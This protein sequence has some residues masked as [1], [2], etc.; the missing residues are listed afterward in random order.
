MPSSILSL[1]HV[2][3]SS[4]NLEGIEN[5]PSCHVQQNVFSQ[6]SSERVVGTWFSDNG[7]KQTNQSGIAATCATR[8]MASGVCVVTGACSGPCPA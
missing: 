7:T 3:V 1:Q 6:W 4:E 8:G 2:D 5:V